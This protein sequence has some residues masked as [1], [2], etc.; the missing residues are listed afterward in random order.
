[1]TELPSLLLAVLLH[2]GC[3]TAPSD[4]HVLVLLGGSVGQLA[5][6]L[7]I[8]DGFWCLTDPEG[9]GLRAGVLD[10]G[11]GA[12]LLSNLRLVLV[13]RYVGRFFFFI[14]PNYQS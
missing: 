8:V 1:M 9:V 2:S 6:G 5:K 11:G 3:Q 14:F 10:G 7:E 12:R 13:F 4:H